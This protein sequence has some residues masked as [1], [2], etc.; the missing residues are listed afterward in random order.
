MGPGVGWG[1][2]GWRGRKHAVP[3]CSEAR[4]L[5]ELLPHSAGERPPQSAEALHAKNQKKPSRACGLERPAQ[6]ENATSAPCY[7]FVVAFPPLFASSSTVSSCSARLHRSTTREA[8][9]GR[10]S[11]APSRGYRY[12][13]GYKV[14]RERKKNEERRVRVLVDS[15]RRMCGGVPATRA[16]FP[17]AQ[18]RFPQ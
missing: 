1:R 3:M 10:A 11:Q 12:T 8:A 14:K 7:F 2:G 13:R 17:E 4:G 6:P 16:A 15:S 9:A 5:R 18:G